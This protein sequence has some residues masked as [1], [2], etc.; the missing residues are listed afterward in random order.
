[1]IEALEEVT[2]MTSRRSILQASA[3]AP[4]GRPARTLFLAVF[5]LASASV[6][7]V[8]EPESG[9][10]PP[11]EVDEELLITSQPAG[12]PGGRLVVALRAEPK[13]L[14]PVIVIDQDTQTL[15]RRLMADLIHINRFSQETEGALAKSW[16]VSESGRRYRLNLRRGVRFSDGHPFDADD[17]LFTFAVYLDEKV[18]SPNRDLLIVGGEP[19]KVSK[20][21]RYT[22]DFELAEA[23]AVGERLFDSLAI[24]PQH[25]LR[26]SYEQG[27]MRDAW[28]L[29]AL[30]GKIV[31]LGPFRFKEYVP[32]ERCV[33]E[34]NPYYWK[35]DREGQRLPYFDEIVF[36]FLASDDARL[37]RFRAG[38]I[39]VIDR[40]NAENYLALERSEDVRDFRLLDRGPGLT[41]DFLF[42]NLN[43]LSDG[44]LSDIRARQA[45][46]RQLEF[47][48]AVS[49]GI[50][51][52]GIVRLV[53]QSRASPLWSHVTPGLKRWINREI[54]NP[55][56]S[57]AKARELLRVA[58]FSWNE[59]KWLIDLRGQPVEFSIVTNSGNS[60]RMQMATIIQDDLE[61]LG[62][63]VQVVPLENRALVTRLTRSYDYEA[64]ILGL[65]SGDADPNPQMPL[66][67]SGGGLHLW[68]LGQDTPETPWEAEIDRLMRAQSIA[69]DHDQRKMLF[70]SVQ[71]LMADNLP[72]IFLASPHVLVGAN[73]DIGNFQP[74]VLDHP[75]LWNVD[76][77][78]RRDKKV[79]VER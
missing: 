79:R 19:I 68:H 63:R 13:T 35:M 26:E 32:G 15:S 52:A 30:A 39:D 58:G 78:Y 72:I 3:A 20:V 44:D 61:E 25:V 74:A 36:L 69:V 37:I 59:E 47:R 62:M 4:K 53:F 49:L 31:G 67:L 71:K 40:L 45:W 21:D 34:R 29:A 42:F 51:R 66:L 54:A 16:T 10:P 27:K 17:V 38:D 33:L 57:V 7:A 65:S 11:P 9:S 23:Y 55:Q 75:T 1:M 76:Q 18:A 70:D 12:K 56:R 50:D 8:E 28:S 48:R 43:D 73:S 46:F 5:L 64:C 60:Q 77:M 14:N 2:D 6:Y 22:V 41:Y 24:L